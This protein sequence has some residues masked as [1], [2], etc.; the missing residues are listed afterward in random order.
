[1]SKIGIIKGAVFFL[2]FA[3]VFILL[4]L[5]TKIAKTA[6][7]Q[8]FFDINIE[9]RAEDIEAHG[10]WLYIKSNQCVYSINIKQQ[11]LAGKICFNGNKSNEQKE[12]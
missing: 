2:T 3:I 9:E 5:G 11:R 8:N 6:L 4:I 1:M 12:K 10:D 7:K